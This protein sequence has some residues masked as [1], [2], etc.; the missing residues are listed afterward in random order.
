MIKDCALE[1]DLSLLPSG[2]LTGI[3]DRGVNLSGGQKARVGLARMAY[4]HVS[5]GTDIR[6]SAAAGWVV[7]PVFVLCDSFH[8]LL[9]SRFVSRYRCLSPFLS[10]VHDAY[11]FCR[12][13]CLLAYHIFLSFK[14]EG[15]RGSDNQQYPPLQSQCVCLEVGSSRCEICSG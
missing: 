9:L 10:L 7:F 6:F 3:G 1:R 14:A 15:V 13:F 8:S 2:D 12:L 11:L 4:A 5:L